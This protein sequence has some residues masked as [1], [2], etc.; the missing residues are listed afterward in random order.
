M[1]RVLDV[2]EHQLPVGGCELARV[3]EHPQLPAIEHAVEKR[4]HRGAEV[5]FERL[6]IRRKGGEDHAV[7]AGDPKPAQPVILRIEI[8]GHTALPFHAPPEWHADQ[9]AL[10]VIGPLVVRT[11]ELG[12]AAQMF[13]AELHAAV[14]ATIFDHIDRAFLVAHH[15]DRLFP[16]ESTLEIARA[17]YLHLERHVVPART[18]ENA[19]IDLRVGVDPIRDSGNAFSGPQVARAHGF[20]SSGSASR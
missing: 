14:G 2:L 9:I 16:Y 15:H 5:L 13:L 20:L 1:V 4:K 8:R 17:G 18:A 11:H 6:E 10:E 3:A 7:A 12:G 19:L